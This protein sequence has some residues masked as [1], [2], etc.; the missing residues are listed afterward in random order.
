MSPLLFWAL[1]SISPFL[2]PFLSFSVSSPPP[3]PSD[4]P[5]RPPAFSPS[6]DRAPHGPWPIFPI[7]A[8]PEPYHLPPRLAPPGSLASPSPVLSCLV[9]SLL[10]LPW[11]QER[12]AVGIPF[13]AVPQITTDA[14]APLSLP[15]L[16]LS[17][18][19][20]GK[21]GESGSRWGG[22]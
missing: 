3:F 7:F 22:R 17:S 20:H 16:R 13:R 1:L 11:S 6:G 2:S 15:P 5:F 10:V 18:L 21:L 19:C 14:L 9:S 8:S 4:A 12:G